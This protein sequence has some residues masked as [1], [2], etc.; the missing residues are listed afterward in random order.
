MK[1]TD[2]LLLMSNEDVSSPFYHL[3]A[4]PLM[5]FLLPETLGGTRM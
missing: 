3:D 1:E 4:F 2:A 5:P